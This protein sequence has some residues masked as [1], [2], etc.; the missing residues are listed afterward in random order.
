MAGHK[1]KIALTS[2]LGFF[3]LVAGSRLHASDL[4][5]RHLTIGPRA[6]YFDPK[7]GD[8]TW[9]GGAQVRYFF[10]QALAIEGSADY[11]REKFG[12]TRVDVV[13]VQ[14]SLLAYIIQPKPFGVYL[15]GGTGWYY[16]RIN[17]PSPAQHDTDDRFG[18]HAGGGVE[19]RISNSWSLDGSYRYVWID[20]IKTQDA[21][22]QNKEF[23]DKGQ[24]VTIG[25]N[26]NF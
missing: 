18:L 21:Q 20:S 15:L 8:A 7:G 4:E 17:P 19:Y 26:Y 10:T 25:L 24:M 14:A 5:D 1:T 13:P 9:S 16:R 6:E 11:R 23:D 3:T 2:L 22:L 12:D